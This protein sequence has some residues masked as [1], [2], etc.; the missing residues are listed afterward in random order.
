M[1]KTDI[2]WTKGD[3][4]TPGRVWNPCRGCSRAR[5]PLTQPAACPNIRP[6]DTNSGC[7]VMKRTFGL[8]DLTP[9]GRP[10]FAKGMCEACY[11]R[12]SRAAA[13]GR[14]P[15]L[16]TP[17]AEVHVDRERLEVYLRAPQHRALGKL[18]AARGYR[19]AA[20]LG[21]ELLEV[22]VDVTIEQATE[23]AVKRPRRLGAPRNRVRSAPRA[24]A[25]R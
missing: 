19:T 20:Q 14:K 15:C 7:T 25:R 13:A 21:A 12:A 3:D 24:S 11:R 17:V 16:A 2:S 22:A 10:V 18:A 8:A 4:G 23:R 1:G 9:C 5:Q 6:M